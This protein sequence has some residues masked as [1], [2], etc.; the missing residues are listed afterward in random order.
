ME[1]SEPS[2]GI[3]Y[4]SKFLGLAPYSAQKNSQGQIEIRRSWIFSAYSASLCVVMGKLFENILEIQQDADDDDESFGNVFHSVFLT[5]RGL[6]FDAN[7]KI[8]VRSNTKTASLR[9]DNRINSPCTWAEVD[10]ENG[11]NTD[12]YRVRDPPREQLGQQKSRFLDSH[13]ELVSTL[14]YRTNRVEDPPHEQLGKGSG[15]KKVSRY[16]DPSRF[17]DSHLFERVAPMMVRTNRLHPQNRPFSH[18]PHEQLVAN[19]EVARI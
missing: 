4:V 8:P 17:L 2:I 9:D 11:M 7:S 12:E 6:L 16:Q 19:K 18:P 1:I 3:F 15:N 10:D 14:A 5:Y 13:L